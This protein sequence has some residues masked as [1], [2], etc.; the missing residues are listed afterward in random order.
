MERF[1]GF[2]LPRFPRGNRVRE[3]GRY[4]SGDELRNFM[5]GWSDYGGKR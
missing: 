3:C 1:G 5:E 2:L 4:E